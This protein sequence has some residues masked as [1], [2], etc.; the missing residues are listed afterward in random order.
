MATK[1]GALPLDISAAGAKRGMREALIV[2]IECM[3]Q[4]SVSSSDESLMH[5]L[6]RLSRVQLL[7]ARDL[8]RVSPEKSAMEAMQSV[9]LAETAADFALAYMGLSPSNEADAYWDSAACTAKLAVLETQPNLSGSSP[10]AVL[11]RA[12]ERC[13]ALYKG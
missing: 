11:T 1:L 13:S 6:E 3:T 10:E 12:I 2:H 5:R 7:L 8:S 9:F 4:G